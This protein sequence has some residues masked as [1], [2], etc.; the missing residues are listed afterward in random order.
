MMGKPNNPFTPGTIPYRILEGDGTW[1][2]MSVAQVAEELGCTYRTAQAGFYTIKKD[3][4]Y[5]VMKRNGKNMPGSIYWPRSKLGK[6]YNGDWSHKTIPEIA[7]EIDATEGA[8][9][10]YIQKIAKETGKYIEF[11]DRRAARR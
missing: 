1:D 4:N 8:V 10:R 2:D 3:L 6:L 7:A 11:V 9:Y 5:I